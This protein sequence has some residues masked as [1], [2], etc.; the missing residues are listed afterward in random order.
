VRLTLGSDLAAGA[1][2]LISGTVF[3]TRGERNIYYKEYDNPAFNNGIANNMDGDRSYTLFSRFSWQDFTLQSL[4]TKREKTVPTAAYDTVFNDSGNQTIDERGYLDLKFQRKVDPSLEL[5]GRLT[6]DSYTYLGSYIYDKSSGGGPS[7]VV[8]K[9]KSHGTWFG[10]ELQATKTLFASHILTVGGEWRNN[11]RQDQSNYDEQ[12]PNTWLDS[13]QRSHTIGLFLQDSWKIRDNLHL[14]LGARYD[15]NN[16]GGSATSPRMA[17]VYSP[18]EK[19]AFKLLYG[20]AFR[21]P[22]AYELYYDDSGNSILANSN[23]KPEKISTYEAVYEQYLGDHLRSSLSGFH[24][25][26]NNLIS[27]VTDPGSGLSTFQNI[28]EA[29]AYGG[30]AE[31]EGRWTNELAGRLSYSYQQTKDLASGEL[32]SNSPRHL[33]KG[34]LTLP[35]VR[36]QLFSTVEILYTSGRRTLLQNEAGGFITTNLTLFSKNLLP[37][38]EISASVYNLFDQGYGDPGGTEHF[39]DVINQEGRTYR[40]KLSYRF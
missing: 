32:L 23:L 38:M 5:L 1:T 25:K 35:L 18:W 37:G 15:Y 8:N 7:R 31:V 14:T 11:L 16:N 24:Y 30:G 29:E 40:A 6:Y 21:A 36:K 4:L 22:N 10:G 34:N 9:D 33:L 17:V 20:T 28:N 2:A 13:K 39:Q 19:G 27:Q 12:P 26:I 3:D